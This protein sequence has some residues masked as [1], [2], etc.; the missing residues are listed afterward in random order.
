MNCERA[1]G[2]D[3]VMVVKNTYMGNAPL[4]PKFWKAPEAY[5]DVLVLMKNIG[6]NEKCLAFRYTLFL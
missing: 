6:T 2:W 1:R 5:S 4:E 3:T